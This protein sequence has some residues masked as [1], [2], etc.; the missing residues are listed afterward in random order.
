MKRWKR[1]WGFQIDNEEDILNA[2]EEEL[3]SPNVSFSS[4]EFILL[5]IRIQSIFEQEID[6]CNTVLWEKCFNNDIQGKL[7][8]T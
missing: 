2:L 6:V 4:A 1:T 8:K 5:L 7:E 3:A